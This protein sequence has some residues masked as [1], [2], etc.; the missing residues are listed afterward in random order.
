M[1]GCIRDELQCRRAYRYTL[2]QSVRHGIVKD[3]RDYPHTRAAIDV[4]RGVKRANELRA[5]MEGVAYP[6]YQR[7]RGREQ[8]R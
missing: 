1:D 3:Y 5:F 6:R 7:T 8:G 4:E 2:T